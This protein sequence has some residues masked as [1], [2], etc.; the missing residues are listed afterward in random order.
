MKQLN[1]GSA[2]NRYNL[3]V[4]KLMGDILKGYGGQSDADIL[5]ITRS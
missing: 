4:L 5:N 3:E 1:I 2:Y